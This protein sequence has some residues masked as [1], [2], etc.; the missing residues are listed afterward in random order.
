MGISFVCQGA[1]SRNPKAGGLIAGDRRSPLLESH[2]SHAE[3]WSFGPGGGAAKPHRSR[4]SGSG[5][6]VAAPRPVGRADAVFGIASL[7]RCS[8]AHD[9]LLELLGHL[10]DVLGRP[11]GDFHTQ[12]QPH[13]RKHF[14]DFVQGLAAEV[15]GAQHLGFGL[16][17]QIADIDDVVVLQAVRRTHRQLQLVDLLEE[18]TVDLLRVAR[19]LAT[20]CR[21]GRLADRCRRARDRRIVEVDEQRQLV[22]KDA[23]GIGHRVFRV[24][25][26]LSVAPS[27]RWQMTRSGFIT[28]I[29]P[30]TAMSPAFTSAGPVADSWRRFG[31]SPCI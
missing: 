10:F 20:G 17:D 15:R 7:S 28:S 4:R 16:A 14:L 6:G 3:A 11:A 21:S 1:V 31:P 22:L 25:S 30:D 26:M 29:S 2:K 27:S 18:V 13:R 9:L 12:A 24:S 8:L 19:R 23:A 5:C